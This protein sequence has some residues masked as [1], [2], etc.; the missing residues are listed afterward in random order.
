MYICSESFLRTAI[1]RTPEPFLGNMPKDAGPPVAYLTEIVQ[2]LMSYCNSI[3]EEGWEERGM[4]KSAVD[5]GWEWLREGE[6]GGEWP[7]NIEMCAMM[8]SSLESW[9]AFVFFIARQL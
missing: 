3:S 8:R 2:T 5:Q 1:A 4:S 7:T 6:G 9:G